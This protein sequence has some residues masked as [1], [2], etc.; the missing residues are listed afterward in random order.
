[1]TGPATKILPKA[2][3][4]IYELLAHPRAKQVLPSLGTVVRQLEQIASQHDVAV[5]EISKFIR[6]DQSMAVRIIR[7]ANSAYFAPA[8][9][10]VDL[11][12]AIIYLGLSNVRTVIM[13][14]Q[15]IEN[16][17]G[18][19]NHVFPWQKFWL[20]SV[21][22]GSLAR[23][24][25]DYLRR[26]WSAIQPDVLYMLGLLHDIG[27]L[28]IARLSPEDFQEIIKFSRECPCHMSW[29][30]TEM[31]GIDHATIG[32]WYLQQQGMPDTL[33]EP[34]RLHHAWALD[35]VNNPY[36]CILS[37]ADKLTHWKG[38]GFSGSY[39]QP[40]EIFESPEWKTSLEHFW[41]PHLDESDLQEEILE[42]LENLP[43]LASCFT[44]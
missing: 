19:G 8:T 4:P 44:L 27:K 41:R 1:M 29:V 5:Q 31:F 24:L 20:H 34:V 42:E 21:A 9:P 36:A 30:E 3:H 7:L 35:P 11:D 25:H 37:L 26:E 43:S 23:T 39:L 38:V 6:Y 32:S 17:L 15:L 2:R 10:I 12:E 28:V 18:I 22:V 16:T 40:E 14:T 33:F 13:T